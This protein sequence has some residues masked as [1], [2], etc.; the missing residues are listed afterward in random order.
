MSSF[1]QSDASILAII[2]LITSL[3]IIRA[4]NKIR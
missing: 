1:F 4:A 2:F 3:A